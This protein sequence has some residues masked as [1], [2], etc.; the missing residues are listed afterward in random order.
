MPHIS[1][2]RALVAVLVI[3]AAA[4]DLRSRRIPNW[5][6]LAGV[7]AGLLVNWTLSG[8]AGLRTSL[9]GMMLGFGVYFVLYLLRAMG[10][11]DVKLMAAVGA[12]VGPA[13][14]F[15][16]FI[17]TAIAG[18]VLAVV[19]MVHSGRVFQTLQNTFF[20]VGELVHLR[21]PFTRRKD[22]DVKNPNA[23][24]MPHGVAIAAGTVACLLL[25]II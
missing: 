3:A 22:L 17:A 23:L 16:I 1:A 12:I 14:W 5:L 11:G 18:G 4:T 24:R 6:T 10:A 9:S 15:A 25:G 8:W 7:C 20:I 2:I 13:D 19:L 21:A